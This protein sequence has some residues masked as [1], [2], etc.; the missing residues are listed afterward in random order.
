MR[1]FYLAALQR[2]AVQTTASVGSS[3]PAPAQVTQQLEM[4]FG[5]AA[6]AQELADQLR[7]LLARTELLLCLLCGQPPPSPPPP[8]ADALQTVRNFP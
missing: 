4:L 5:D 7:P 2:T 6:R 1:V 8:A 3:R